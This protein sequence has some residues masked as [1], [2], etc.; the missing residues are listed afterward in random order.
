ML[1]ARRKDT[2]LNHWKGTGKAERGNRGR[3]SEDTYSTWTSRDKGK[4]REVKDEGKKERCEGRVK[5]GEGGG[6]QE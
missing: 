3:V 5:S 4:S 1:K 6:R 2:I